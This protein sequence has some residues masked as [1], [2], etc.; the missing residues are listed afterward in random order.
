MADGPYADHF[1]SPCLKQKRWSAQ[2]PTAG[3]RAR[4]LNVGV[5][6]NFQCDQPDGKRAAHF[7]RPFASPK[8]FGMKTPRWVGQHYSRFVGVE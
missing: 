2:G 8:L 4:F 6:R 5:Y 1:Q 3:N 7:T